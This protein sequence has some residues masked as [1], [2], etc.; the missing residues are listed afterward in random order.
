MVCAKL[1]NFIINEK[2]RW[3]EIANSSHFDIPGPD[4]ENDVKGEA[5]IFLKDQL[6]TDFEVSRHI[7]QGSGSK[8]DNYARDIFAAGFQRAIHR[9]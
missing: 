2:S 1:H 5:E 3:S 9:V 7:R 8:R 4:P 6:H